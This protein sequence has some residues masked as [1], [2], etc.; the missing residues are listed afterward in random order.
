MKLSF[1]NVKPFLLFTI[2][3]IFS[4]SLIAQNV[5][6]NS[7]GAA[8]NSSA[9]L[10]IVSANKGLLIPRVALTITTDAV[11]IPTPATSLLVYNTNVAMTNG[12]GIG[13]YYNSG[14]SA[15]PLWIKLS[16]ANEA[17]LLR[18][19][20]GITT[21][22]IPATYG[23]TVIGATENFLGT[24]DANDVVIGTDNI[25]RVRIKQTSG[26]VGIATAAPENELQIG[27]GGDPVLKIDGAVNGTS[28]GHLRFTET[29]ATDYGFD[30]KHDGLND[31]LVFSGISNDVASPDNLL[32][33]KRAPNANQGV[34][35]NAAT[36]ASK[37]DINGDLA[38][39]EGTAIPVVTGSNALTL[40][41]TV[42]HSHYRLT[43]ALGAF[44][45]NT[46]IGGNDGQVI[47]L[48][49]A[50][51]QIITINNNNAANGI[52]TGTGANLVSNGTGNASVTLIYNATLARWVVTSHTGMVNSNDWHI[53]G[54]AATNDPAVPATYGTSTI[55]TTENWAGTTDAN[56]Y[57]LGTN[58]IER[59][60]LKQTTGDVGIGT[61]SPVYRLHVVDPAAGAIATYSENTYVGNSTGYG[62]YGV[63]NNNPGY[64]YGGYFNGGG[65]G[66]RGNATMNPVTP[67]G[68]R[69]GGYFTGWYGSTT[70]YGSYN[71]GYGGTTAY[72]VYSNAIGATTNIGGYFNGSNDYG[73]IVPTGGG[74]SGFGTTA[75][76]QR[77]SVSQGANIDQSDANSGTTALALTFG[78]GSGEGIGSKRT[79]TGNQYGLDFYQGFANRMRIWNDG[80]IVIG[81]NS[82]ASLAPNN[83]GLG[84]PNLTISNPSTISTT[85]DIPVFTAKHSGSSGTTW[86]MG[87]IEYYTEGEANIG[88]TYQLCPLNSNTTTNLGGSASS[89]YLSYRW[90]QLYCSVA[91]NVS[92]DITLK[93]DI[94]SVDYGIHQLRK[95]NPI[96]Y[97]YKVDFAGTDQDVPDNEKRT[98]I[99]FSAQELKQIVPELVSS[100]DYMTYNEDG[101]IKAK[102]PTLGVVYEEMIPITVN[103]IKELD[104]QQQAII[105]TIS[106]SDF[107]M[108]QTNVNEFRVNFSKEFIDK[109]QGKPIVTITALEP[110]ASY[111]LSSVDVDGFTIKNNNQT[112]S[113]SF[114][115]MAMAKV[116]E[117]KLDIPSDY[118]EEQ[119]AKKLKEIEVFEAS[120]PT[121]E[122]AIKMVKAKSDAKQK[123]QAPLLTPEQQKLKEDA[124]KLRAKTIELEKKL[125]QQQKEEEAE[126]KLRDE[127]DAKSI[128]TK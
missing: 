51:T 99:G 22:A 76:E 61:A 6:V 125:E 56:D 121:N 79:T 12:Q 20:S 104:K 65:Y 9:M 127:E 98:H 50:A 40:S 64:G 54:N 92:S 83:T 63:S 62:V 80:N 67:A 96:S 106:I 107:G 60:R 108:E 118:T 33:L 8:P 81:Q 109:L 105:K 44:A 59:F 31:A 113:M 101:Y 37:L 78:S 111:Y 7:T 16:A 13:Y 14:T 73:V 69:Y 35:I 94:K 10:D 87:S 30:I 53:T 85:T 45:I 74:L 116:K 117:S 119:H 49:N 34:A 4:I 128:E 47:T 17:W 25:E 70:N 91:P 93:K 57:V 100:W 11:T 115:W 110:N 95:I 15:A 46:I 86:Q 82:A 27:Q 90:N 28:S 68:S 26:F 29:F 122:E 126:R 75:P 88:F 41:P 38:L 55:A 71:Y 32:V 52:L 124:E 18:G 23:T 66:V 36:P 43:G 103:A 39:R 114:N 72:G 19:N 2:L 84:N 58:N 3:T 120:L 123:T 21:P 97:K 24:T 42:Q 5:G 77:L 48:I 89:K 1:T 112:S 102:T